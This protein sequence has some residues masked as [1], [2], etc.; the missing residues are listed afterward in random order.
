MTAPANPTKEGYTF[1][2][3]DKEIPATIPAEDLTIK[4]QWTINQ[5]KMT[6]MADG[7]QVAEI[8]QDYN[9]E[10]VAPEAPDKKGYTFKGWTPDVPSVVPANDITFEAVYELAYNEVVETSELVVGIQEEGTAVVV[11]GENVDGAVVIPE[12]VKDDKNETHVVTGIAES[13]FENDENLKSVVIP[14]TIT[15]IGMR[16]FAGCVNLMAIYVYAEEPINLQEP[17]QSRLRGA[18]VGN[19]VFEDV[20]KSLCVLYVPYGC[21]PKYRSAA[22]WQDFV[23]IVEMAPT[24]IKGVRY[25]GSDLDEWYDLNG[26]KLNGKPRKPG[27]YILNG[28]KIVVK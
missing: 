2:G 28:Q 25:Y 11:G 27:M 20:D 14:S 4:A 17:A 18:Q 23:N 24:A 1:A 6:F 16:A 8:V 9:S 10:L 22:V 19:S 7:K 5:Y 26:F 15:E 21:A 13:A 3:W 12:S